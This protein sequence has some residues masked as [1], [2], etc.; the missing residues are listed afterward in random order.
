MGGLRDQHVPLKV[1]V[2][3]VSRRSPDH[4]IVDVRLRRL[5]VSE[6]RAEGVTCQYKKGW[7]A[8]Q[9]ESSRCNAKDV[10]LHE[11]L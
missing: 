11:N 7:T 4:S 3:C 9:S 10:Q 6:L 1:A 5:S 2:L 8:P